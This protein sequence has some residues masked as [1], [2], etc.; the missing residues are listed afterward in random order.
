MSLS[1]H[2]GKVGVVGTADKAADGYYLI[3]WLSEPYTL[4]AGCEGMSGIISTGKIV[5]GLLH[6]NPVHHAQN[7][8]TP[9]AITMVVEV[10]HILPTGLG[11]QPIRATNTLPHTCVR[12]DAMQ[13]KA[14][15]VLSLDNEA[16]IE[17]VG[18]RDRL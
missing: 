6:F 3:K 14:L 2:K 4:H 9:S 11:V 12:Q 7:W 17:E 10:K 16:I 1:V 13:K 5:V 15:K 8:Y 18:K